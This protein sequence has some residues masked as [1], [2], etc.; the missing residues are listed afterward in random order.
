MKRQTGIQTAMYLA[1]VL[2]FCHSVD[3]SESLRPLAGLQQDVWANAGHTLAVS[4]R[5]GGAVA[6]RSEAGSQAR[7]GGRSQ[8][9][10]LVLLYFLLGVIKPRPL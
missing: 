4:T 5:R 9:G 10:A 7:E 1:G 6:A 8:A 2:L 3:G